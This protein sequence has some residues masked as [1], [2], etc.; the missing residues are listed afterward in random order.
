MRDRK[1]DAERITITATLVSILYMIVATILV[2]ANI[3]IKVITVMQFI[4][5]AVLL[6]LGILLTITNVKRS[7]EYSLDIN[8]GTHNIKFGASDRLIH[9]D[10]AVK[11][12]DGETVYRYTVDLKDHI[13]HC[14]TIDYNNHNG[15]C[16][17]AFY[18]NMYGVSHQES[19]FFTTFDTYFDGLSWIVAKSSMP[20]GK[21][22]KENYTICCPHNTCDGRIITL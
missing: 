9:V 3:D 6:V 17:Y 19:K 12:D 18:D 21:D 20:L 2:F 5:I 1:K 10:H 11:I 7:K 15:T 14:H 22:E 16:I 4:W 13:I 8:L